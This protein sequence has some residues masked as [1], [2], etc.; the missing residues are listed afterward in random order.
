MN[1]GKTPKITSNG[2]LTTIAWGIGSDV[3][4]AVEGSVFTCGA[5]IQ[6]LRDG[7]KLIESA[8]DSE[9]YARKVPDSGGVMVVPAFSGLGAPWW[10]PYARGV[11]IGISRATT[12]YHVIRAT[13][14]SMA[15]QTNDVIDLMTRSTGIAVKKLKVDGG[16]SSNNLLL[17]FQADILGLT[18]ERPECVE[19]T[20]LGVAYLCGLTLGI[21]KSI[22]E[23]K[24]KRRVE[25]TITSDKSE[26]WRSSRIS[27]WRS[28]V[29]RSLNW[30]Q[31]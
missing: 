1:I 4:Y 30:T 20:A 22:D 19:T 12:K 16:A 6:W 2:L 26:E 28:A 3:T 9:Y 8:Q 15:F 7:L 13:L 10:D 14:E 25:K 17:D 29:N 11:I 24:A 21:Y 31:E 5:A 27:K 23:I 18:L